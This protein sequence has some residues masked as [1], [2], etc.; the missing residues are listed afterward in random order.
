MDH[1]A[2]IY[3]I[4]WARLILEVLTIL[5]FSN[6][7][8][9]KSRIKT[10]PLLLA[11]VIIGVIISLYDYFEWYFVPVA[12]LSL[13]ALFLKLLSSAS[14]WELTSD[15]IFGATVTF[16]LELLL[17]WILMLFGESSDYDGTSDL[18]MLGPL[19]AAITASLILFGGGSSA[20]KWDMV[21][22]RHK[23]T[24]LIISFSLIVPVVMLGNLF[25]IESIMFF[26]GYHMV[27]FL[28]ALY[29]TINLFL[30]KYFTD[31]SHKE[32][33]L[34][35]MNE[36][37]SYL[38]EIIEELNKREHEHK[39]QLNAIIGIAEM[40]APGCREQ[41]IQY[42]EGLAAQSQSRQGA[43]SIVSENSII[44]AY[45][46]KMSRTAR[47]RGIHLDCHVARPFPVY[48]LSEQE[49]IELLANLMNNALEAAASMPDEKKSV[50]LCLEDAC[51][52]VT[53]YV[54]GSFRKSALKKAMPGFSTKGRGRGYGMS[55]IRD[56]V[57][58]HNWKIETFLKDDLLT[59][60]IIMN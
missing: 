21:L 4:G 55:N 46:F 42:A 1:I 24:L 27:P 30:I 18:V 8:A 5:C 41:I 47:L 48:G 53:N 39:N 25:L 20:Q 57:K 13:C 37:G 10:M 40:N 16:S 2:V 9:G 19:L 54:N 12:T 7:L 15:L 44:A 60:T 32:S 43:E 31:A 58:K 56:I 35:T 51:I 26:D 59:I 28:A 50:S 22:Q 6:S 23:K 45:L 34:R 14:F 52:E 11:G 33:Q 38:N 17:Q 49:L 29:F 3:M 36:Y